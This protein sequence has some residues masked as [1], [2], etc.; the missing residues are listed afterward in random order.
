MDMNLPKPVNFYEK[1]IRQRYVD[2]SK[3]PN[4]N[5]DY[6][7]L[8]LRNNMKVL[9]ISDRTTHKSAASMNVQVGKYFSSI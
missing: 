4:D 6:R 2:I 1:N 7:G 3:S 9:L 8:L 5:R